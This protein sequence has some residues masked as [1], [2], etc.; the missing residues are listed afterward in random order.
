MADDDFF[1]KVC[2]GCLILAVIGGIITGDSYHAGQ[3]AAGLFWAIVIIALIISGIAAV[4]NWIKKKSSSQPPPQPP[5]RSPGEL[6]GNASQSVIPV[7]TRITTSSDSP[8]T[9]FCIHCGN[10]VQK[11]QN[12]CEN[13]G[14]NPNK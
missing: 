6:S 10:R 12:F 11:S 13:C 9:Q 2:C 7:Q 1:G 8:M 14:K 4:Y 5:Q 3:A